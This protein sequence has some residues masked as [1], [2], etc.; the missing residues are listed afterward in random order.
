M[1]GENHPH[2][3]AQNSARCPS[4]YWKLDGGTECGEA[5]PNRQVIS[6]AVWVAPWGLRAEVG[7]SVEE[8][9]RL[10]T[11]DDSFPNFYRGGR[12][13][14]TQEPAVRERPA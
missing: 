13:S 4:A 3:Y 1:R 12:G 5:Q 10:G 6:V 9:Q 14:G 8:G 7:L 2:A 11:T